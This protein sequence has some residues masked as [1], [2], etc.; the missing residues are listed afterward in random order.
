MSRRRK[1]EVVPLKTIWTVPDAVWAILKPILDE[2]YPKAKTGRPR[3]DFRQALNGII[4][5]ARSG[6][7]WNQL[8]SI[9]GDDSSVHRWFQRWSRDDLFEVLWAVLVNE[10]DELKGL[11]WE[12]QA[13]DCCLGK[14]RFPGEKRG[15]IRRIEPSPEPRRAS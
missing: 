5:I 10:C 15:R 7:Q 3:I 6:C 2:H 1:V 14:A 12:W 11:S 8:P 9:F 13:A 4:F